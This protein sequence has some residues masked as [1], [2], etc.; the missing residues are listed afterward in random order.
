MKKNRINKFRTVH[1]RLDHAHYVRLIRGTD[2]CAHC[3]EPLRTGKGGKYWVC[4]LCD[5]RVHQ[6][7]QNVPD[8][9][10]VGTAVS[11][12]WLECEL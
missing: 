5:A 4:G 9:M 3:G 10:V 8:V 1:G 2:V 6:R 7:C 11:K 12:V